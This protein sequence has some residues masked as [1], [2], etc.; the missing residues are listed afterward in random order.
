MGDSAAPKAVPQ[1][2]EHTQEPAALLHLAFLNSEKLT[3]L[4]DHYRPRIGRKFY[5]L[6][7]PRG[8]EG[9][10]HPEERFYKAQE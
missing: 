4:G 6:E 3:H 5:T 2:L 9:L 7:R 10:W 8:I 1:E